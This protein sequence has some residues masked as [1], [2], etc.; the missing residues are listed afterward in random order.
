MQDAINY[1]PNCTLS[2]FLSRKVIQLAF[3]HSGQ[4]SQSTTSLVSQSF[5][6]ETRLGT[7]SLSYFQGSYNEHH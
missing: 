6:F 4:V 3:I 2:A 5:C 7:V 1:Q